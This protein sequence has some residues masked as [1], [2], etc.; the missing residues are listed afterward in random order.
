MGP[1]G[2]RPGGD[3]TPSPA[4]AQVSGFALCRLNR[5]GTFAG[6]R[7]G[8]LAIGPTRYGTDT[9]DYRA[10]QDRNTISAPRDRADAEADG[11]FVQRAPST[12]YAS[13]A[14]HSRRAAAA[15]RGGR[16]GPVD[17]EE[18]RASGFVGGAGQVAKPPAQART[19]ASESARRTISTRHG[20][21]NTDLDQAEGGASFARLSTAVNLRHSSTIFVRTGTIYVLLN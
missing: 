3:N 10:S 7:G 21:R 15:R 17:S 20:R 8:S 13:P 4:Q 11:A 14:A 1:D 18:P 2:L 12:G 6:P 16:V 19:R 9:C 5:G